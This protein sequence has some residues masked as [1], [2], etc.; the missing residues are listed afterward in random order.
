MTKELLSQRQLFLIFKG[1]KVTYLF[2]NKVKD[3]K[4]PVPS[5][6]FFIFQGQLSNHTIKENTELMSSSF[7][8]S[9]DQGVP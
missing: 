1:N 6:C 2:K 7:L 8:S 3:L 5:D 9:N 4:A